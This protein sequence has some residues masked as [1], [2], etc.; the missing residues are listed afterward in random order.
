VSP[1]IAGHENDGEEK[2]GGGKYNTQKIAGKRTK[3]QGCKMMDKMESAHRVINEYYVHKNKVF[4]S[5]VQ[6]QPIKS[7]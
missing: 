2:H 3:S 7:Y 4:L 6:L 1:E 5:P